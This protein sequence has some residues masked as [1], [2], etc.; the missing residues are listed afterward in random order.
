MNKQ[1]ASL[2]QRGKAALA[3][4]IIS[5]IIIGVPWLL[6]SSLIIGKNNDQD[7]G[8]LIFFVIGYLGVFAYKVLTTIRF[9]GSTL[10]KLAT[11]QQV[12]SVIGKEL[13]MYQ[14]IIRYFI[15][16]V[17]AIVLIILSD[18]EID[19]RELLT[20][21]LMLLFLIPI[22]IDHKHRGIHDFIAGTQVVDRE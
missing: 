6:L 3:D 20:F 18:A 9:N 1:P 4:D 17:F 7:S 15:V 13:K 8:L 12:V 21:G 19:N 22:I 10:G 5:S 11:N 14:I 2:W 16:D